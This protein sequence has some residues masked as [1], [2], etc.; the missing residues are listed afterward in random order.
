MDGIY[1]GGEVYLRFLQR[2]SALAFGTRTG[3]IFTR[4][5][6]MPYGGAFVVLEGLQHVVGPISHLLTGQEMELLDPIALA[7]DGTIAIGLINSSA[8]RRTFGRYLGRLFGLV[9]RVIF[10]VP[11]W[12]LSR[13][14]VRR[15]F[16]SRAF[17][18]VWRGRAAP[19]VAGGRGLG[20]PAS[21]RVDRSRPSR[22]RS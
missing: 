15:V 18:V 17:S 21:L 20:V 22:P 11:N 12:L 16:G 9:H 6:A 4:Y 7:I 1:R 5:L 13:D 10:G 14:W 3:R 8:F 19:V 2:I